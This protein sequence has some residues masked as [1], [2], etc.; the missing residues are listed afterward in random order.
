MVGVRTLC[1]EGADLQVAPGKKVLQHDS[2]VCAVWSVIHY[3]SDLAFLLTLNFTIIMPS[4][5]LKFQAVDEKRPFMIPTYATPGSAGLDLWA[6]YIIPDTGVKCETVWIDQNDFELLDTNVRVLIPKGYYGRIAPRSSISK[7]GLMINAG[8]IDSDYRGEIK[9]MIQNCSYQGIHL[10]LDKPIA[11]LIIEK[12]KH[13]GFY[14]VLPPNAVIDMTERG[15]G[16]F[17]SSDAKREKT[18]V[19]ITG[20]S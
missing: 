17:G 11:Q 15:E 1:T 13:F 19:D 9:I 16:G 6:Q 5:I 20:E 2:G 4:K 7:L 8:V 14:E 18:M 12:Y 10:S 3:S